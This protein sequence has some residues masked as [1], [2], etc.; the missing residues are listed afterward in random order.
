MNR[1][2]IASIGAFVLAVYCA[3][4]NA[5]SVLRVS[6]DSNGQ[7]TADGGLMGAVSAD[8]TVVAFVSVSPDLWPNDAN[9]TFDVFV[10]DRATGITT[11]VSVDDS[12]AVGNSGSSL[13]DAPAIS[14]DGRFVAFHSSANNLVAGDTNRH[15]DVFVHDRA[16]GTT[17]RVSVDS[18]GQE[19]DGH[20]FH[21]GIS[22]DGRFVVF[23]SEAS[24]LVDDDKNG[25]ADIFVH[26]RATGATERV[27][28]GSAGEEANGRSGCLG[29]SISADG[30]VV[31]FSSTATNLVP[32]DGNNDDDVFVRIRSTGVTER[33]SV[34][35]NG[36]EVS[37]DSGFASI[38]D[39]GQKVVYSSASSG[40][41]PGDT[42]LWTD[43]FLHDR[44]TGQTIRVSVDSNGIE[45]NDTSADIFPAVISRDGRYVVFESGATNFDPLDLNERADVFRHD[46]VTGVTELISQ[47][48]AC[49]PGN[50]GS[51]APSVNGDGSVIAFHGVSENF[52][53]DDA[54][55]VDDVFL[56]DFNV[57]PEAAFWQN[58]GAGFPGTL[59]V[60]TLTMSAPPV[61][62]SVVSLDVS[63]SLGAPTTG[64]MLFGFAAVDFPTRAGGHI[65]ADPLLILPGPLDAAGASYH[66]EIP[67]DDRACGLSIFV[68]VLEIDPGA[69]HN[70]SFTPGI[71][72]H[73][74]S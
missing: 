10:R 30:D 16:T 3:T 33:V 32:G 38:S 66:D 50:K 24:N 45:A 29:S 61:I 12:A 62:G 36:N 22:T 14:A 17:E 73:F 63:N 64:I 5:Q 71:E 65:L 59:G 41:V 18:S 11:C 31:T 58:Y 57:P 2:I 20:S 25:A 39:D 74:G 46:L 34:D 1:A 52:V 42:N 13:G 7:E 53:T 43:V 55:G 35:S 44:A 72:I 47:T 54:N 68:Q 70:I 28:V 19:S 60:P 69:A 4:A 40:L 51:F 15:W 9:G 21:P 27:S 48:C 67:R 56:Y 6:L 37:A 23:E 26:D 49:N 8:G